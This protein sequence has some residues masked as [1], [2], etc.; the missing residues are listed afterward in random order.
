MFSISI[1]ISCTCNGW[2]FISANRSLNTNSKRSTISMWFRMNNTIYRFLKFQNAKSV[3]YWHQ[4]SIGKL[5]SKLSIVSMWPGIRKQHKMICFIPFLSINECGKDKN[6]FIEN[7]EMSNLKLAH[8][9]EWNRDRVK[10]TQFCM[11]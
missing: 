3:L 8:K 6:D 7:C 9:I 4:I 10:H 11:R 1:L 2:P 5:R